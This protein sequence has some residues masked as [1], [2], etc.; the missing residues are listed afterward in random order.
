M[1]KFRLVIAVILLT[2]SIALLLWG[3]L[4]NPRETR[5]Q[6]ISPQEMELPTPSSLHLQLEPVA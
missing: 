1:K 6:S 2:F 5:I 3:Y 4:P